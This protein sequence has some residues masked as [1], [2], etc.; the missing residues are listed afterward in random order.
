MESNTA[1]TFEELATARAAIR[2]IRYLSVLAM[3]VAVPILVVAATPLVGWALLAAIV[4]S[5]LILCYV[6]V[7]AARQAAKERRQA[8]A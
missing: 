3:A 7:V 2:V 6:L 5:P 8:V 4:L 1:L